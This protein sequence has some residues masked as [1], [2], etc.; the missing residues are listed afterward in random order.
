MDAVLD[1]VVA[2]QAVEVPAEVP[3][4]GEFGGGERFVAVRVHEELPAFGSH[5]KIAIQRV[6]KHCGFRTDVFGLME[7]K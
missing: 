6:L 2:E 5:V 1:C 4:L 7:T 3:A